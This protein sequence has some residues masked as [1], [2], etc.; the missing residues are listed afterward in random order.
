M[1]TKALILPSIWYEGLP[2]TVIEAFSSGTPVLASNVD[3]I[4]EIVEDD[5]NGKLFEVSN[6]QALIQTIL[7]FNKQDTSK[8]NINARETYLK[9]YSHEVNF[10]SLKNIYSDLT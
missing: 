7:D 2:N 10:K 4:N 9:K 5:Y 8:F 3:N 6:P 1:H